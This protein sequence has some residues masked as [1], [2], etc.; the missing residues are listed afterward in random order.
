MCVS[1]GQKGASNKGAQDGQTLLLCGQTLFFS[2]MCKVVLDR[3]RCGMLA[4]STKRMHQRIS[5]FSLLALQDL[6]LP[7]ICGRL[8]VEQHLRGCA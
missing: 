3:T 6:V 7:L 4:E 2:Q 8:L 1:T 5:V